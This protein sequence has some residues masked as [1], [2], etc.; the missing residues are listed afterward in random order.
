ML[1]EKAVRKV[2]KDIMRHE[3][4]SMFLRPNDVSASVAKASPPIKQPIKKAEAG[5]PV[6]RDDEH[7]RAHS[8]TVEVYFGLS[9]AHKFW[10]SWQMLEAELHELW[11]SVSWV[12]CHVGSASVKTVMKVCWASKNHENDTRKA[13]RNWAHPKSPIHRSIVESREGTCLCNNGGSDSAELISERRGVESPIYWLT[14]KC[15][16]Y[17]YELVKHMG[18]GFYRAFAMEAHTIIWLHTANVVNIIYVI[19]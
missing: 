12:Q 8:E 14:E 3:R 13:W 6:T 19:I 11:R 10:G 9:Q 4:N 16:R 7:S 1:V 18:E 17:I 5:R 2:D 15:L